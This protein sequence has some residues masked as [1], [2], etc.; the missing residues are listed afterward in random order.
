MKIVRMTDEMW[1]TMLEA[2]LRQRSISERQMN[3][4]AAYLD[5]MEDSSYYDQNPERAFEHKLWHEG[6]LRK[7]KLKL[8]RTEEILA[9][10]ESARYEDD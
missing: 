2:Q 8:K 10:L 7:A 9:A 6:R 3:D 5:K 4:A 1:R